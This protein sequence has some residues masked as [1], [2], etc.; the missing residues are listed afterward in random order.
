MP[1]SNARYQSDTLDGCSDLESLDSCDMSSISASTTR[2]PNYSR[3][4]S[5]VTLTTETPTVPCTRSKRWY[6]Q[7]QMLIVRVS[8]STYSPSRD[9]ILAR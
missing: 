1:R 3:D 5:P 6:F 8:L 9:R 4:A 2:S 7:P